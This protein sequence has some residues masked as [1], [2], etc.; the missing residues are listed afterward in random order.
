MGSVVATV[1][2][3]A[4]AATVAVEDQAA[5]MAETAKVGHPPVPPSTRHG[6]LSLVEMGATVMGLP[7]LTVLA[8]VVVV[9]LL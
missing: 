2:V 4:T 9:V 6:T 8:A 3:A 7:V 5:A 1:A